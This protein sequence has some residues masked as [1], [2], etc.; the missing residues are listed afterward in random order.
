[1]FVFR[2]ILNKE[3]K[4]TIISSVLF[5]TYRNKISFVTMPKEQLLNFFV[6]CVF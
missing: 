5:E 1:M 3:T 4:N 6:R 2:H